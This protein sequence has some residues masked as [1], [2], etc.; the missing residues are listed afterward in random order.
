MGMAS[1][2]KHVVFDIVGTC[3]GYDVFFNA[4]EER[5]GDK[6]RGQ[7]IK[8]QLFAFAWMADAEREC[9]FLDRSGR[10]VQFWTV[11]KPLFYRTLGIA[12]VAK[13]RELATDEDVDF[14]VASYRKLKARPGIHECMSRLRGAGFTI[15][16]LTSGDA[17]RVQGYLSSN[18]IEI[19]TDNFVACE[20]IGVSKPA[21]EVYK[22]VL[23]KLPG[24]DQT[25][26]AAAH[27]WDSS[28]AK[29][30]G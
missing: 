21:P 5:I 16:A 25:W 12:G 30:S 22:Y 11:F 17:A 8:P 10:Y 20:S 9:S 23:D 28:A 26:F 3:V 4:I 15:W 1:T 2:G 7:G 24:A 6:L 19:P 27:M 18:G 14:L 29:H 13:P